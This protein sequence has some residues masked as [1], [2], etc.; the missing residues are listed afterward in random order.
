MSELERYIE[1]YPKES[2][3]E[4]EKRVLGCYIIEALN[5]LVSIEMYA[6]PLLDQAFWYLHFDYCI[7][8][9]EIRYRLD[10]ELQV[11][12]ETWPISTY[13]SDWQ[14]RNEFSVQS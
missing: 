5:D 7:H 11:A 10:S 2:T 12:E 6:R 14:N 13:L 4:Y 1:L 8:Q 9:S 3:R